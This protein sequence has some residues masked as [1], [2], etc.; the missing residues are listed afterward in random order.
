[1]KT[2]L[3]NPLRIALC[4]PLCGLYASSN[5]YG[6]D[7]NLRWF[8]YLPLALETLVLASTKF[9]LLFLM[10]LSRYVSSAIKDVLTLLQHYYENI[11]H[12]MMEFHGLEATLF[13]TLRWALFM[14]RIEYWCLSILPTQGLQP[15]TSIVWL[16][17]NN[18][19]RHYSRCIDPIESILY[20]SF[21]G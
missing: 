16:H 2:G 15:L 11:Q 21:Y 19:E 6:L 18:W 12:K 20:F 4:H 13:T 10:F 1:M 3:W 8:F 5:M 7:L 9:L 14:E 17:I